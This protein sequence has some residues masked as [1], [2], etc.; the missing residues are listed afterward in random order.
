MKKTYRKKHTTW[1]KL[2]P[3]A[4]VALASAVVGTILWIYRDKPA[5]IDS[6]L[7]APTAKHS[8]S[9]DEQSAKTGFDQSQYSVND[10]HSIWVVVNKGRKLPGGYTPTNLVAPGVMA[11][12]SGTLLRSDIAPQ[13]KKLF[14]D[15]DKSNLKLMVVS[16]YRSY[17]T[18][19]SV[20]SSYVSRD[21]QTAADTYSARPG[22]SE[23]QT[24]LAVDIGSTARSCELEQCFGDTAEGK[25]LATNSYKYGFIIRYQQSQEKLTGYTYEP[26]HLRFLGSG[27]ASEIQGRGQT[28]EQFF[29]LSTYSSYPPSPYQLGLE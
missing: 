3:L 19:S 5:L 18:Q 11:R 23:H 2:R 22:H 10:A 13:L 1:Q 21:G 7:P 4:L 9:T 14:A 15:A 17:N 27:L 20:Y 25:W 8:V 12:S 6:V 29:G 26:W 16:G 24:G 28:L